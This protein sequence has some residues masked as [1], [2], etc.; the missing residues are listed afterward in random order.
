MMNSSPVASTEDIN[1]DEAKGSNKVESKTRP[2]PKYRRP[3]NKDQLAVLR[4][5]YRFRFAASEQ[6]AAYMGRTSNKHIQKRLK[7]L[8]E[9]G[10]IGKRYDKSYR[11]K[12]QAAEYFLTPK[13][14]RLLKSDVA[15]VK[16][17]HN[18]AIKALYKNKTVS[19]DFIGHNV[20]ILKTYLKLKKLY[21]DKTRQFMHIDML[22][23]SHFR[24]G[25]LTYTSDWT[26]KRDPSVFP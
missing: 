12:G 4:I 2:E 16:Y 20:T 19:G 1:V 9:Q 24:R 10:L 14:A 23:H 3:L 26:R 7:I 22:P 8:E 18:N 13:G 21:N 6:I 5:L 11:I 17:V 15:Y 25:R